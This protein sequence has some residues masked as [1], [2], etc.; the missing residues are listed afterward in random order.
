MI[1]KMLQKA[2]DFEKKYLPYTQ[3]DQPRFHVTGGIGW[4]ND[5]NG[6]APYKGEYH[7]FFQY[8]PYDT[9]WGPMH[10]GH[11]KTRDFIHWARLPAALAPDTEY[12]RNGCF[13][14]GA[15]ELPD[16]R[17]L[18]M[19]TGVRSTTSGIRRSGATATASM[20]SSA[21]AAPT[22]AARSSS[23]AART[24]STGNSSA[25]SP[26]ATTSTGGCGSARISSHWMGRTCCLSPRRR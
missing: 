17:H 1:S 13:S 21:T 4:I 24:R 11:V 12:D 8:Y 6:F 22:A 20:P 9:K 3:P 19:Y 18:L 2:R 7:L 23:I 14:G 26:P 15:V 10:W 16:G 25:S 5:P